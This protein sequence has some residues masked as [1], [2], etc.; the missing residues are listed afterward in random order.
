VNA[1]LV[2]LGSAGD[3]HPFVG[4]GAALRSRGHR[5]TVITNEHFGPL[6]RRQGL[7]FEPLGSEAEFLAVMDDPD[8]WHPTRAFRTVMTKVAEM[9]RPSYDRIAG[10]IVPGET[11]V[12]SSMLGF[13]PRIAHDALGVPLVT[14]HLQPSVLR[15]LDAPPVYPSIGDLARWPRRLRRLLFW[16]MDAAMIDRVLAPPVNRFRAELGLPPVR[17]LFDRWMHSPQLVLGLFPDWFGPP[18]RDWPPNVVLTGFPLYD[19]AAV[20]E[21]DPAVEAFLGGGEPPVVV[22]PG[23]AMKHGREFFAEAIEALRRLGRRG[24]FLTRYRDQL[25]GRL[26]GGFAHFDYV[27]FSRILPRA[28]AL[29]HHG[30]IGTTA[31]ALAAGI[32]HLVMPMAHDQ[33]DNA[34]RLE[35]L[36]VGRS[37]PPKRFRAPAVAGALGDLLDS[38]AVAARCSELAHRIAA[39]GDSLERAARAIE[40]VLSCPP[41]VSVRSEGTA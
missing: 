13:G 26:P 15:S 41:G 31:Q 5:V 10:R 38:G 8:L 4:L 1:L 17:R 3:V 14:V 2:P 19:E 35:R 9:I 34:A 25:P 23:S 21:P 16:L 6:V 37:L 36:G 28:A 18:Q 24:A 40:G 39:R 11:V 20:R 33:P 29:V 32:P 22:T 27:P 30:G 12:V 7:E